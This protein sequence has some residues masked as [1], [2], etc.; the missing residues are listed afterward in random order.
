MSQCLRIVAFANE[1]LVA[2]LELEVRELRAQKQ[3]K[4]EH[5]L[6]TPSASTTAFPQ[7]TSASPEDGST[8]SSYLNHM[9]TPTS[10]FL[11]SNAAPAFDPLARDTL[12]RLCTHWFD[13]FQSWFPILHQPTMLQDLQSHNFPSS[14]ASF[15]VFKAM[16]AVILPHWDITGAGT[17]RQR[18]EMSLNLRSQV[19][20]EAMGGLSLRAMQAVLILVILDWGSGRLSEAWNLMALCKRCVRFSASSPACTD[21]PECQCNSASATW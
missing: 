16:A 5:V 3:D 17:S 2:N 7:V 21:S 9:G 12:V 13:E 15:I 8:N 10:A 11:A 4:I 14:A 18:Y 19:L 6:P 1:D 20:T